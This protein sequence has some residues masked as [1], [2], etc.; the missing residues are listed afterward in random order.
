MP[1]YTVLTRI[2]GREPTGE[3]LPGAVIELAEGHAAHLVAIGAL[4]LTRDLPETLPSKVAPPVP[5][6]TPAP[7]PAQKPAP[8][9]ARKAKAPAKTESVVS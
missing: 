5:T 3:D 8:K 1:F 9:R 4:E 2:L 6:Q 7:S